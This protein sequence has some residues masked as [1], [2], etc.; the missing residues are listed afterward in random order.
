MTP[1]R[2]RAFIALDI[3]RE[4]RHALQRLQE[5]LQAE[6]VRARWVRPGSVHLTVRFLGD[7]P[8]V[9]VSTVTAALDAA[10][11][12]LAAP[13]LLLRN[14]G[15]FPNLRRARVVWAGLGGEVET[16]KKVKQRVDAGLAAADSRLFPVEN[17]PFRAHLTLG[18]FKGRVDGGSLHAAMKKS[19]PFEPVPFTADALVLYRSQL[20]PRGAVYTPLGRWTLPKAQTGRNQP[21]TE[22]RTPMFTG[23]LPT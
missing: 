19:A 16:L 7:V 6:G 2:I 20:E 11:A 23:G 1:D 18:R 9:A 12:D 17:R 5:E 10:A 15:V 14:L 22:N 4:V 13:E 3:P 8:A 21:L